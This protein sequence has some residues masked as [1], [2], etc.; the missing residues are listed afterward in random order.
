MS[1]LRSNMSN[2]MEVQ[3]LKNSKSSKHANTLCSDEAKSNPVLRIRYAMQPD[4]KEKGARGGKR[5]VNVDYLLQRELADR[6]GCSENCV[7]LSEDNKRFPTERILATRV[8]FQRKYFE[9]FGEEFDDGG[10]SLEEGRERLQ[11][12]MEL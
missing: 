7:R 8:A 10:L 11:A 12:A 4:D 1:A 5:S 2:N 3:P 6:F 9:L